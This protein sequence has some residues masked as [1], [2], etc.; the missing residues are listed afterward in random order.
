ML[1]SCSLEK[2]NSMEETYHGVAKWAENPKSLSAGSL[3]AQVL[4]CYL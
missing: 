1:A 2:V 3:S 4:E